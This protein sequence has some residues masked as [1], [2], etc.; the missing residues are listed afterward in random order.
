[1]TLNYFFFFCIFQIY[2]SENKKFLGVVL[3]RSVIIL[4]CS[5]LICMTIHVNTAA[6]L[7]LI[8]Q[9]PEISQYVF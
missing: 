2:G 1:M 5:A 7:R 9:D 4:G 3:Q 6:I 8:G